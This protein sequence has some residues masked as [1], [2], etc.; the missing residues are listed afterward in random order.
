MVSPGCA[1][2]TSKIRKQLEIVRAV[3]KYCKADHGQNR[4]TVAE[5]AP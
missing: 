2:M 3:I 1:G 4:D 5:I